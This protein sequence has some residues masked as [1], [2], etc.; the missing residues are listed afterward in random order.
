[1]RYSNDI[2]EI[3]ELLHDLGL[4][5]N[6][7]ALLY[8]S[9]AVSLAIKNPQILRFASNRIYLKVGERYNISKGIVYQDISLAAKISW[10]RNRVLLEFLANCYLSR[11]PGNLEFLEI[12]ASYFS[13]D[14]TFC[15]EMD[16]PKDF[17]YENKVFSVAEILSI[18]NFF[19][20]QS[21]KVA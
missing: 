19:P 5:M 15:N 1:M 14:D 17:S 20:K 12:L 9:Y 13:T 11:I 16:I 4:S 21:N 10:E 6:C 18:N 3:H 2:K 8:T 7:N